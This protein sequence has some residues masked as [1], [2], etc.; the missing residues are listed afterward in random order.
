MISP[1]AKKESTRIISVSGSSK[2]A[3]KS[4]LASYLVRRL[5][6]DYAI[7]VSSGGGHLGA[8]P[9]VTDLDTISKP[10]TDTGALVAAGASMVVWVSAPVETVGRELRRALEIFPPGGLMVIEGNS[11]LEHVKPDFSIFL[12]NVSFDEFKESANAAIAAADVVLVDLRGALRGTDSSGL[13]SDIKKR[14]GNARVYFYRDTTEMDRA[15]KAAA[16]MAKKRL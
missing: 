11:A 2:K 15:F 1:G 13:A 7:K 14:T 10:G 4:T 8:S 5:R 6:A 16:D 9:I 12:M 3:G